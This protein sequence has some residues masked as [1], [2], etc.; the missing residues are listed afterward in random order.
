MKADYGHVYCIWPHFGIGR[1]IVNF[2]FV[3]ATFLVEKERKMFLITVPVNMIL[4]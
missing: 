1:S 2:D 3:C 4:V